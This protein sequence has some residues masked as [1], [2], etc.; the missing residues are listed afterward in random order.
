MKNFRDNKSFKLLLFS[1]VLDEDYDEQ[2][3]ATWAEF[4]PGTPES[5]V[6]IYPEEFRVWF[7][8]KKW[9]TI[10]DLID[11]EDEYG[12]DHV[13]TYWFNSAVSREDLESRGINFS[14]YQEDGWVL[15]D[16]DAYGVE[17]SGLFMQGYLYKSLEME[18][19]CCGELECLDE[20]FDDLKET[21]CANYEIPL[22][23]IEVV[24]VNG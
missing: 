13:V 5:E 19:L 18:W 22:E 10:A 12:V 16:F 9:K 15:K 23:W 3:A 8:D 6:K 11:E 7:I 14:E 1:S 21:H 4:C 17:S 20:F 2:V 24:N